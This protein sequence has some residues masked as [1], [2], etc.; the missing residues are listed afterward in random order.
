MSHKNLDSKK[1]LRSKIISFR[2]S[3]E[4][5]QKID[6]MVA[7]SGLNKQDYLCQRALAEEVVV[8]PSSRVLRGL[9][10][11]LEIFHKD[12]ENLPDMDEMADFA[13]DLMA[14]L[15]GLKGGVRP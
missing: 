5:G 12:L 15:Q 2:V 8:Q 11:Q 6:R 13:G 10:N 4:E 14:I 9:Y 3:P 1:R 7:L